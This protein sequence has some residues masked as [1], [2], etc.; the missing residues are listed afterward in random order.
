MTSLHF[1]VADKLWCFA[2][3]LDMCGRTE[4]P[5]L[6]CSR[7]EFEGRHYEHHHITEASLFEGHIVIGVGGGYKK[8]N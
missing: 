7:D 2:W 8:N 3:Q 6:P 1:S 5:S 4:F